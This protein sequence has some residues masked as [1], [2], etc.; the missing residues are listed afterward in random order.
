MISFELNGC[1][2]STGWF[3]GLIPAVET[4]L[5]CKKYNG[6]TKKYRSFDWSLSL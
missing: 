5:Y 6:Q 3:F 1:G 2:E 4:Y